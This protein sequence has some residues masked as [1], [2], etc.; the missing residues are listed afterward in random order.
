VLTHLY[1]QSVVLAS[2]ATRIE[3]IFREPGQGLGCA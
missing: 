1:F 2:G 3:T